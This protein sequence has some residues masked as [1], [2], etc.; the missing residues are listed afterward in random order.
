MRATIAIFTLIASAGVAS[1]AEANCIPCPEGYSYWH[2][3]E[4][5]VPRIEGFVGTPP[6]ST[7]VE[8]L[9]NQF[10]G[11]GEDPSASKNGSVTDR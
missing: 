11:G 9:R 5:C 10:Y 1:V 6:A 2:S 7:W 3:K 4:A 8:P